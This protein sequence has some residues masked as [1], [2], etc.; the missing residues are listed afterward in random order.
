M[1]LA[2]EK[3][4]GMMKAT[5]QFRDAQALAAF[6]N[7][8]PAG[9]GYFREHPGRGFAPKAWW[10]SKEKATEAYRPGHGVWIRG[11]IS[12][13]S[14]QQ[15]QKLLRGCWKRFRHNV[16]G[17]DTLG[18]SVFDLVELID[19][20][21]KVSPRLLPKHVPILRAFVYL[22][23]NPWRARFCAECGNRFIAP[24]PKSKFCRTKCADVNLARRHLKSWHAHKD[25]W[26]PSRATRATVLAGN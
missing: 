22:F 16:H 7:L 13:P 10:E 26:R 23:E 20:V 3:K 24:E 21:T 6:A 15:T 25:K 5:E 17:D 19:S 12:N 18:V 1:R 4:K 14:W 2:R 9:V 11:T 8:E